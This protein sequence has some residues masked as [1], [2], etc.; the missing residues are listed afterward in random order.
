MDLS[1]ITRE[2][3]LK[4]IAECDQL[5]RD[6]FLEQY[7]FDQ[8][9]QYVLVHEGVHYDSKA[10][11]GVSHRYVADRPLQAGE[12][13]GGRA[14]VMR[15]LKGLGFE[16]IDGPVDPYAPLLSALDELRPH[17][18]PE[19][20]ARHQAI[21]LL[22]AMGRAL[23]RRPRLAPWSEVH[24]ELRELLERYGRPGSQATPEYPFVVLDKSDL[25]E[26]PGFDTTTQRAR[27]SRAAWLREN[28]PSGG[29]TAWAY[30]LV[31][32]SAGARVAAI[33]NLTARFFDDTRPT[34]LLEEVGLSDAEPTASERSPVEEYLRL[35]RAVEDREERGEHLR[36]RRTERE[37]RV[38]LDQAKRAV[39]L[40][41]G[42]HC[43]NPRCTGQPQDVYDDGRPLLEV[44]H[45]DGHAG[46]G[47]DHPIKM[48][49]LCP[50]CHTIRTYGSTR[51]ELRTILLSEARARHDA[52]IDRPA[53]S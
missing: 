15:L 16:V 28:N 2:A 38:R 40:R 4:A 3:V 50:N 13:S 1:A 17:T 21:L 43:E 22:W 30:E 6:A 25:W 8:A 47:R 14:T 24:H 18:T 44:D 37:E 12:F 31:A 45:L 46:G 32:T 49:A 29:L 41:S 10:I 33:D 5:G 19:G 27:N 9:R 39:L 7:G 11:V 36:T 23:Q 35:C 34:A 26:L 52:W 53:D 51:E 20:P 42:G 48:V